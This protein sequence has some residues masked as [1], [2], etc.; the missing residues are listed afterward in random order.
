MFEHTK[1]DSIQQYTAK[2]LRQLE[3]ERHTQSDSDANKID[4]IDGI[5]VAPSTKVFLERLRQE[6]RGATFGIDGENKRMFVGG[7]L[8][9]ADLWLMLPGQSYALARVGYGGYS[10]KSSSPHCYMVYARMI[11]NDK[12]HA[13]RDQ[14]YMVMTTDFERGVKN[15]KK[16]VRMYSPMEYACV[17]AHEFGYEVEAHSSNVKGKWEEARKTAVNS[18]HIYREIK[19]LV[20]CGHKF[21]SDEFSQMV[22]AWIDT[23]TQWN[24]EKTRKVPVYFVNVSVV[25][26]EQIFEIV[27]IE[28]AKG[29]LGNF[30]RN[31][32]DATTHRF[33]ADDIPEDIMG[34]LS[35]LSLLKPGQYSQGVGKRVSETMFWVER[36]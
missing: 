31:W 13:G 19:H 14:Y 10:M 12:Y 1:V 25:R 24:A 9:F 35:V 17:T 30:S 16:Y 28:D 32:A 2:F 8:C 3:E 33:K 36:G 21:L 15:A 6:F 23:A 18:N 5:P 7:M 29:P 26:D 27:E 20:D 34:K 4:F 22:T 11:Q